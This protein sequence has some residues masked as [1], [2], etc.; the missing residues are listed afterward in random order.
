METYSL[1]H[2]HLSHF[3]FQNRI[4]AKAG[5]R[6]RNTHLKVLIC[7]QARVLLVSYRRELSILHVMFL[8]SFTRNRLTTNLSSRSGENFT[9]TMPFPQMEN[10]PNDCII[11]GSYVLKFL[12]KEYLHDLGLQTVQEKSQFLFD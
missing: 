3:V 12:A 5:I 2:A 10:F 7:M 11:F 9:F 8:L 6:S 1:P 4:H